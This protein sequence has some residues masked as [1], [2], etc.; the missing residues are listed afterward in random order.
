M[1]SPNHH[2]SNIGDAFSSNFP[3]YIPVSS[4]YVPASPG[5]TYSS[6]S[7]N[8]FGLV[9]I[10]SPTL[11]LFHDDPY[12]KVMHAYY[13]KESPIPPIVIM[14]PSL[15]L[16]PM[17]NP[18]EFFLL[19]ELLPP[20][21]QGHMTRNYRNKGLATRSNL[22][23]VTVTCHACGEKGHY[24]NQCQ[25]T[26]NNNAQ[27]RA[28][29]LRDR[30]A[31]RDLNVVMELKQNVRSHP[32]Y[33]YSQK[34]LGLMVFKELLLFRLRSSRSVQLGSKSG[35]YD[36][37]LIR[38]EQYFLMTDYS[39]WK[40]IKNDNKDLTKP[41]VS[42]EQIY[43]PTTAEEKQDR[44]NKM[45]VRGTLL[46]ALPNKDQ[47]KFH[48]YQD[49][50]LLMEAIEKRLQKLISQLE[51]QGEVI[52][53]ED[54]NLKL[55]RSL[56]SEW[57][58][59]ALIWRNKTELETIILDDLKW[60]WMAMLTIRVRRFM[61]RIGTSLDMNG[62]RIGFDKTMVECFN[63]HK[64][65][66]FAR[67]CR[68]PSN[69]DNRGR[70]YE[71]TTVP[72]ENPIENALIA[73][74]RIEG[75][76]HLQYVCD[77]K[78]VRQIRNNS[79]RV[80]HKKIANQFTHPHP[81]RGFVPPSVLTRTSKIN[82]AVASV[83][84]AVRPVNAA[85]SQSTM[86]HSRPISKDNPQ[87]K[88]YKEKGVIDSGCSRNMTRNKWYLTNFEAFDDGFVSFG[89][90][91]GRISGKGKIKTG[92]L[93]FDDVYFCMEL[94][95]NLFSIKREYS[96]ARTPQQNRIAKRRNKTLMEAASL[97]A[98]LM[99]DILLGHDEK[100]KELEQEYILIPICTT[101]PLISQDVKDSAEDARKKAPEV[102]VD[103]TS[104]NECISLLHVPMVTPIDDTGI[105]GNAYDDDVLE[106]E[107][108]MNNVDSSYAIPEATNFLKDHPQEQV[109]G[110]LDTPV[111]TRH[112]SKT[113][114]EFGLLSSLHKLK[115]TNHKEF[116][117]CLFAIGTKW[118]YR[119]K[120]DKRRIVI[121]NK[122]RLVAQGH[123]QE[124]GIYYDEVFA[125]VARI[126]AIRLFLAY[127]S[128]KDFLV[129]QMDDK[130]AFL[131]GKIEEVVYVCQ[132]PSF[133]D[134]N[135]LD[136]VY[137]V[138]KAL[139]G[140]HQA[141]RACQDK[142][143]AEI[144]KKFDFATVKTE[145][146]PME[147]N[148]QLIKD[149]EAEDVDVHLYRSMIGLLVYLTSSRPNITFDV[150]AC[151]R[152][153]VTSKT[154]HL[155][156]VKRIFRYLKGQPKLG[157]WYP[158]DSPFDLEA[159]S[160]SDYV[161][162]SLGRKSTTGGCKFLQKRLVIAKDGRCFMDTSKVTTGN[163]LLKMLDLQLLDKGQSMKGYLDN[164]VA[165][166]TVYKERVDIMERAATTTSNLKAEQSDMVSKRNERIDNQ[167]EGKVRHKEMY[168]ISSHTKKIFANMRRIRAGFSRVVTPFFENMMVQAAANTA[169]PKGNDDLVVYCDASH[170][171]LEAVL[172]QREKVIAYASRQLKLNEENYTTRDLEL[173]TVVFALKIW[174]HYLYGTKCIMFTDHKSL[175]HILDQK[176]LN[177]R[178]RHW[179]ELL[180]DYDCEIHYQ[181]RKVN[182]MAD[183]SS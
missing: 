139:Y 45:K 38:I 71:R 70:E 96:I 174:R 129:Y 177:M 181:P 152:F 69:Q 48:S 147:S 102:D 15:M 68:A 165:D 6:S 111:Q 11:S 88:E 159:Y 81:K 66:H 52:Q 64:N 26:T 171:G 29:M 72:V 5:K 133:K 123:T 87:Q 94:K 149:E 153:Q 179:L 136:K 128:L 41:V 18:Q 44:R 77:K 100:K 78:D 85:G 9:P 167:V 53:P 28:Y 155:H 119:N 27:G 176:E 99:R 16:S 151:A 183:T 25:K 170:Q 2:T 113:H 137:K 140:L 134:P 89:D 168:V 116:Q 166:E 60:I 108:D 143:V 1:S 114:E 120:K 144:L 132:P 23:P 80:N 49:A 150:C 173:G 103:E 126:E 76:E 135:F 138:E 86:N 14:P 17:F 63:C 67:E 59:H 31:H 65:G 175:Q 39:L 58:T 3:D 40:V 109:I 156:A 146:T 22:L 112:M 118:V 91:K 157:I 84:T 47:L 154:L 50:K 33:W 92:K 75:I 90:R 51:L 164:L 20:K 101:G 13:A 10:A 95:Y 36:L 110:R 178:Q 83:N 158:K 8:S 162:A 98:K 182:I 62:Q 73:Q 163:T 160:D 74:D 93:D 54:M 104:D 55:L 142:Y 122:A 97:E 37:L 145:S 121:K 7:N 32:A 24:A 19:E 141:P 125:I 131:Y 148:K 79:N 107:V 4:D 82:T 106:E 115:R 105:F 127:A 124:E 35:E 117:N 34:L 21:K 43:E 61:K 42:N 56:P 180:V 169:L 130:S 30:N 12:M 46:M 161:G 172:M 57:K